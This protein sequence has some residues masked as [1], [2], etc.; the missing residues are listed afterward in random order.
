MKSISRKSC[1]CLSLMLALSL[2]AGGTATG[3]VDLPQHIYS[4]GPSLG[5]SF[6]DLL[7]GPTLAFDAAWTWYS[8]SW[9]LGAR[10]TL[11][12]SDGYNSGDYGG[13]LSPY[14]EF[15]LPLVGAG[16]SYNFVLNGEQ[17]WGA[18]LFFYIPIPV[19]KD[20]HIDLFFRPK[21]IW[22]E[23]RTE[24]VSEWGI[25]FKFTNLD[26]QSRLERERKHKEAIKKLKKDKKKQGK[27]NEEDVL[28]DK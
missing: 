4:I 1:L 26:R 7:G 14:V 11:P 15:T 9:S 27:R 10:Y 20:N 25:Y 6:S 18:D 22:L 8:F 3:F 13:L 19:S 12:K 2:L 16:A 21:W 28:F 5:Y 23:N 17:G 24:F